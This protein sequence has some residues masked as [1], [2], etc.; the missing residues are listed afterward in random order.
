MTLLGVR[1][2]LG[3]VAV[4]SR[5]LVLFVL[6]ESAAA[7]PAQLGV[8]RPD[9]PTEEDGHPCEEW[10]FKDVGPAEAVA[11]YRPAQLEGT[12]GEAGEDDE[13]CR[14][15]KS[16]RRPSGCRATRPNDRRRSHTLDRIAA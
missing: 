7:L 14:A 4:P 15:Q 9:S 11:A 3:Q 1:I 5:E 13:K 10:P 6:T 8:A 12:G 16:C 2:Q